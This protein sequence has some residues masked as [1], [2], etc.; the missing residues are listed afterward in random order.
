MRGS[1]GARKGHAGKY[2]E[3]TPSQQRGEGGGNATL[4][5]TW[6]SDQRRHRFFDVDGTTNTKAVSPLIALPPQSKKVGRAPCWCQRYRHSVWL[7]ILMR[8]HQTVQRFTPPA[9][10]RSL[11]ATENASLNT[12]FVG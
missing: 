4:L 3:W 1:P 2:G 8:P 9:Q 12:N 5:P 7:P 11:T 10:K 6:Q